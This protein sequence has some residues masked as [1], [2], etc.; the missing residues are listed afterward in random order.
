MIQ[1]LTN[2][3]APLPGAGANPHEAGKEPLWPALQKKVGVVPAYYCMDV[4]WFCYRERNPS[5]NH[6]VFYDE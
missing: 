3:V 2:C 6:F 1:G 5:L 4:C